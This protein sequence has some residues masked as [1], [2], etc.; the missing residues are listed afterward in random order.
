MLNGKM[1]MSAPGA[2]PRSRECRE[3]SGFEMKSR[4]TAGVIVC[5]RK[6][7]SG[8]LPGLFVILW[9]SAQGAL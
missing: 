2:T 1:G 7:L 8:A 9:S 3:S 6:T 4:L 5:L